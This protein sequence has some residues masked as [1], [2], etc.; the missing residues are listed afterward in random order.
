MAR[1]KTGAAGF[2]T[3]GLCVCVVVKHK[4]FKAS[5]LQHFLSDAQSKLRYRSI[6]K[7]TYI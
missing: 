1:I 7:Q 3:I 2:V 4:L 6:Q 5:D